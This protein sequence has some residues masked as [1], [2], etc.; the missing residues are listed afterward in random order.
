MNLITHFVRP[1]FSYGKTELN[2][3]IIQNSG[4]ID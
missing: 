1:N 4:E 2:S 3:V